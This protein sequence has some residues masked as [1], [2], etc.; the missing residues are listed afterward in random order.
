MRLRLLRI[1]L[2]GVKV[3]FE[4]KKV[5]T[6]VK[7]LGFNTGRL[8][9]ES[10]RIGVSMIQPCVSLRRGGLHLVPQTGRLL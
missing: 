3:F 4:V 1:F 7:D 2:G 8:A 6:R 10:C 5:I 9:I